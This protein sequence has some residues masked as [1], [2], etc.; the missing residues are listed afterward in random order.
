[1]IF[2]KC[3]LGRRKNN[4]RNASTELDIDIIG[5]KHKTPTVVMGDAINYCKGENYICLGLG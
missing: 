5:N 4:N 3:S 1:M 2:N